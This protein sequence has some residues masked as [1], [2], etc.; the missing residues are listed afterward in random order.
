[1]GEPAEGARR[2]RRRRRKAEKEV[3]RPCMSERG[4]VRGRGGKIELAYG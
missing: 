4:C 3:G 1:M 2:R